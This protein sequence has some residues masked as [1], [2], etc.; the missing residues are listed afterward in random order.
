L[1]HDP[2][3]HLPKKPNA[4][5]VPSLAELCFR[6]LLGSFGDPDEFA[7]ELAPALPAHLRRDLVRYTAVHQP[8]VNRKLYA[9]FEPAGHADGEIVVVGPQS[10][11]LDDILPSY[12][13]PN[14]DIRGAVYRVHEVIEGSPSSRRHGWQEPHDSEA[15]SWDAD[16]LHDHIDDSTRLHTLVVISASC[17]MHAY[18]NF[19]PTLTRLALVDISTPLPIHRLPGLCPLLV[20]LDLSF[21]LWVCAKNTRGAG[22]TF[23]MVSWQ[24]WANLQIL[25]LRGCIVD[26]TMLEGMNNGRWVDIQILR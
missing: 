10:S 5:A 23:G 1:I 3:Y 18:S 12:R 21:N 17:S 6:V 13:T 4:V 9:L 22:G 16:D 14:G 25:G 8:L 11:L 24:K 20:V 15:T 19:P 7:H 2:H 26:E